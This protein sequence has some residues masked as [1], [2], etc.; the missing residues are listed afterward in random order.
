VLS[1]ASVGFAIIHPVLEIPHNSANYP[2]GIVAHVAC[3]SIDDLA[4][5]IGEGHEFV[6]ANGGHYSSDSVGYPS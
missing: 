1:D 2:A 6:F 4:S 3:F 5:A